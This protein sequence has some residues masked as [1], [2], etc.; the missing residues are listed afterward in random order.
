[1]TLSVVCNLRQLTIGKAAMDGIPQLP[2]VTQQLFD[3]FWNLT[4]I[5]LHPL[6]WQR[7]YCFV[8]ACHYR[9]QKKLLDGGFFR[10]LLSHGVSEERAKY[11]DDIFR[12][13][14]NVLGEPIPLVAISVNAA[15][16][17][18]AS[19]RQGSGS[20]NSTQ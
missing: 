10:L 7:F 5:P 13:C 17:R 20:N 14:Y 1:M 2:P 3:A 15:K 4:N 8:R 19:M 16:V 12:H 11:L 18:S 9:R 6:D